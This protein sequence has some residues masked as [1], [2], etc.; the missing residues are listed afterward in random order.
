MMADNVWVRLMAYDQHVN[1][2]LHN[3]IPSGISWAY[4]NLV[5]IFTSF[6]ALVLIK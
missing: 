1:H 4:S 3:A 6:Y 2:L 5:I